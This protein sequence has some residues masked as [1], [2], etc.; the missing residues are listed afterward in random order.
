MP[1]SCVSEGENYLRMLP[2]HKSDFPSTDFEIF[3]HLTQFENRV[4]R[5]YD[6]PFCIRWRVKSVYTGILERLDLLL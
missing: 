4:S 6:V 5:G 3:S 1:E 2:Y